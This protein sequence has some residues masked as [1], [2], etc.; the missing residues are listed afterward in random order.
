M[1]TVIEQ[2]RKELLAIGQLCQ[3]DLWRGIAIDGIPGN[4]LK[5][6]VDLRSKADDV[7]LNPGDLLHWNVV[8]RIIGT[9]IEI[10]PP[11]GSAAA[12]YL[13]PP[14]N[15]LGGIVQAAIGADIAPKVD[16]YEGTTYSPIGRLET[17]GRSLVE[18][19]AAQYRRDCMENPERG[20]KRE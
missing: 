6:L 15:P 8:A 18:D 12:V 11:L 10:T 14:V 5:D 3:D 16:V 2:P 20:P 1:L 13:G 4:I 7:L 19:I 9:N 17:T